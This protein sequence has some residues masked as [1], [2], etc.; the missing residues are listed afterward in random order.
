MGSGNIIHELNIG[1]VAVPRNIILAPLAGVADSAFRTVCME[2]GAGM[3]VSEM[4][5]AKGVHY[6]SRG[7]VILAE[8][9]AVESPFAVQIFGHEPEIMAEA[10]KLFATEYGADIIDINMG[11]PVPK[12]CGNFE[13]SYLMTQPELVAKIVRAVA[14]AAGVPVTVKM[15][16]GFSQGDENAPEIA[17]ICEANG[18]A[19]VAVHGRFRS[20]YYSGSCDRGVIARVKEAVSVPVI[21][22]GDVTTREDAERMFAEIGC[23]GIMIGRGALGNPWVFREIITGEKTDVTGE[24]IR[25]TA[26]RQLE[27]SV[28]EKGE[29]TAVR[30]IK[31]HVAWYL[32]GRKNAATLKNAAFAAS[33]ADGIRAVLAEL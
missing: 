16:R 22:S 2:Y 27:L 4:I 23:D 14:D 29:A 5:S 6:G 11:C 1:G 32:K 10:A 25:A 19:A 30:E 13:G 18:C 15:R 21:A 20:E 12:V 9:S 3:C 17:K 33:D 24:L 8:H 7:S 26:L 28:M 31:K